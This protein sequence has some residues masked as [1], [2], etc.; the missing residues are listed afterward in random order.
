M[1]MIKTITNDMRTE[2]TY[3][4]LMDI[5]MAE[6]RITADEEE[7]LE[8]ESIRPGSKSICHASCNYTA[9]IVSTPWIN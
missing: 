8:A 6:L 4:P 3:A 9:C 5:Y 1:R 7:V 2:I